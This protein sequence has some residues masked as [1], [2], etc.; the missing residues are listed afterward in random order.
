[1][2]SG[3]GTAVRNVLGTG[4]YQVTEE[5]RRPFSAVADIYMSADTGKRTVAGTNARDIYESG[6]E[7]ATNGLKEAVEILRSG[8][9]EADLFEEPDLQLGQG[10]MSMRLPKLL[11]G[12]V[13]SK[14]L[15]AYVNTVFRSLKAEDRI[16]RVYALQRALRS[17][18]RA[19]A[20][21]EAP[22]DRSRQRKLATGY[23]EN[24]PESLVADAIAQ[25]EEA[26][27]TNNNRLSEGVSRL[28]GEMPAPVKFG[29]DLIVPFDKTPTN[30]ILRLLEY[31]PVGLARGVKGIFDVK[32]DARKELDSVLTAEDQRRV[33][34]LFGRG[35]VGSGLLLL[36]AA[37]GMRGMATGPT[38]DETSSRKREESLGR[39]PGAVLIGGQW[40]EVGR[41]A[42]WGSLITI[43]AGMAR[44][45]RQA[46]LASENE[47]NR[48]AEQLP[49]ESLQG[50][51]SAAMGVPLR[52]VSEI[53]SLAGTAELVKGLRAPASWSGKAGE[54]A[55][56]YVPA[57]TRD[58][59]SL[60]NPAER[61]ATTGAERVQRRI[62]GWKETLPVGVTALGERKTGSRWDVAGV[63]VRP[64][65]SDAL[66]KF[67]EEF[68][69]GLAVSD[70]LPSETTSEYERRAEMEGRIRRRMW[71]A[72]ANR[73]ALVAK[74]RE[75]PRLRRQVLEEVQAEIEHELRSISE[76]A[77][78]KALLRSRTGV[79]NNN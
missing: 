64:E 50:E 21:N 31:S 36:G 57:F 11:G 45:A 33:A 35:A 38:E 78:E 40:I 46:A 76:G 75:N 71:E 28:K 43:G 14:V 59:A 6:V 9:V 48:P 13:A 8:K 3:L 42:P 53:P 65:R 60:R 22:R 37:L 77:R 63:K 70:R 34:E 68:N 58:I 25:A 56:S 12:A 52:A 54:I 15:N 73:P 20:M 51:A 10:E 30:I 72:I 47:L 41:L 5:M 24:P 19:R 62:P 44:E 69:V 32:R 67:L 16:F 74:L 4:G 26:V 55:A 61:S 39:P 27:F 2:L 49:K 1:M 79:S 23:L 18:A 7:A 17:N 66:S 29:V